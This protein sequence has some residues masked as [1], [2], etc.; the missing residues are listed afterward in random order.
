[1]R[2]WWVLLVALVFSG[3]SLCAR[4]TGSEPASEEKLILQ[5]DRLRAKGDFAAAQEKFQKAVDL[6]PQSVTALIRLI[7]VLDDQEDYEKALI[8]SKKAVALKPDNETAMYWLGVENYRMELYPEAVEALEKTAAMDPEDD[9]A[10]NWLANAYLRTGNKTDA[11]RIFEKELHQQS[12]QEQGR[13]MLRAG[14]AYYEVNDAPSALKW[15]K[16][17][18]AVGNR[19]SIRWLAWAYDAGYGVPRDLGYSLH[20]TRI[21]LHKADWFPR[22]PGADHFIE[23]TRGWGLV[24]VALLAVAFFSGITLNGFAFWLSRGIRR[25]PTL[26]WSERARHAFPLQSYLAYSAVWLGVL[27]ASFASYYPRLMLPIPYYLFLGLVVMVLI[28]VIAGTILIWGRYI[29][30]PDPFLQGLRNFGVVIILRGA[31]LIVYIVM[32]ILLPSR[33]NETALLIMLAAVLAVLWMQLGG[34]TRIGRFLFLIYP[35]DEELKNRVATVAER[36]GC[37]K[38]SVWMLHWSRANALALPF[39]NAIWVT[40]T[41]PRLLTPEELDGVIAHEMAHLCES[42]STRCVRMI[43]SFLL[44]PLFTFRMWGSHSGWK[45]VVYAYAIFFLGLIILK[46]RSRRMEERAD[47]F[48]KKAE[49]EPGIYAR[50]LEK[51]YQANL[52]PAVMRGKKTVHP[53]LY[54][55][56]LAAGITPDY[57]R[58]QPPALWGRFALFLTLIANLIGSIAVWLFLF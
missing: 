32:S 34:L 1:M 27:H 39:A 18:V 56:M 3:L 38:P 58:P 37:R 48:G 15:W 57:P 25:D 49:E 46:K 14:C 42:F 17:G 9:G 11:E 35:A 10:K 8:Y 13:I 29:R 28:G 31:F 33:M 5:G 47:Q 7:S 24:L 20:L 21:G 44:F 12:S 16:R 36:L 2:L 4:A 30:K 43:G 52:I 54:D 50:A 41:L 22:F 19:G 45:G 23:K 6:Y 53:H 51:L 55:R 26:H 40:E